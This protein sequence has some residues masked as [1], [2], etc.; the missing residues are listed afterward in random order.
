MSKPDDT[1]PIGVAD[2]IDEHDAPW[3]NEDVPSVDEDAPSL[4]ETDEVVRD[5]DQLNDFVKTLTTAEIKNGEWFAK[6]L[7][8]AVAKYT[9]KVNWQYFQDKYPGV[10]RDVIVDQRIKLAARYAS[11][12]GGLSA[13]AYTT[14]VAA[15]IGSLS[16]ASP[17]TIPA[18]L[19]TA[20]VDL[21]YI[22]Q[23]QL[24]LAYDIS[25]L[26]GVQIDMDDP[27]DLW[28]LIKVAF[29]I[30]SGEFVREGALKA[31][32]AFVRPALRMYYSG[33]VLAAAK[34]L[35]FVGKYLLQRTVI[36]IAI[37]LVGIPLAVVVNHWT[38]KVA[39]RHA[40]AVF[41]NEARVVETAERLVEQSK[42]PQLMLWVAW[43]VVQSD[44]KTSDDEALM[45]RHLIPLVRKHHQVVDA[46]LAHVVEIIPNE[47]WS[48][49][50][51]AEGELDDVVAAA[52]TVAEID[53]KPNV[54]ERMMLDEIRRRCRRE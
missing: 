10:P 16:G 25:F 17:V 4:D 29:T 21:T 40:R 44:K 52:E 8:M 14:A 9:K 33:P 2:P 37:P 49:I 19:V 15:T 24:R 3:V 32:P 13:S 46:R 47:V 11:I 50:E 5:R 6:L 34:G 30:R 36:K 22:T 31:A 51:E 42:H 27:E 48:R 23:L 45:M 20:M 41:R 28:K 35:P 54:Q 38:T 39:G 18:A 7:T 53:G 12:E 43:L 1:S 26:Y